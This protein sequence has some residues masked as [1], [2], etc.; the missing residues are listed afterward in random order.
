[1][2]HPDTEARTQH[3]THSRTP[4]KPGPALLLSDSLIANPQYRSIVRTKKDR[5]EGRKADQNGQ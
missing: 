1:M 5:L 4:I 3:T 2:R